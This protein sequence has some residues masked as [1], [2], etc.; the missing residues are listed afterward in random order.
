MSVVPLEI[1]FAFECVIC[2]IGATKLPTKYKCT[3]CTKQICD[4]CFA[5]HILT[6][7]NCVFCRSPLILDIESPHSEDSED[8]LCER[9]LFS[10][11]CVRYR[12][13]TYCVVSILAAWYII[14]IVY[15]FQG[16]SRASNLYGKAY[17]HTDTI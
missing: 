7:R 10:I 14:L 4:D 17:N 9:T 16:S 2:T 11:F 1:A 8:S 6:K 12:T 13:L 3:N 15:M 5:R